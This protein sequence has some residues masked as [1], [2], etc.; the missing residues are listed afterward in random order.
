MPLFPPKT[1]INPPKI[2]K[3]KESKVKESKVKESKVK[4]SKVI[5][6]PDGGWGLPGHSQ[7]KE[8]LSLSCYGTR[9]N[10]S[11]AKSEFYILSQSD[12]CKILV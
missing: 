8:I 1:P 6:P 5:T 2:P 4:E 11:H 12:E 7:T 3:V 10:I 9:S